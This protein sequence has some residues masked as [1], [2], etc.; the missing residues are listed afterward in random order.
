MRLITGA[1]H[2]VGPGRVDF[3]PEQ[4]RRRRQVEPNLEQDDDADRP[5]RIAEH[6]EL[7]DVDAIARRQHLPGDHGEYGTWE[8]LDEADAL[9]RGNLIEQRERE[10]EDNGRHRIPGECRQPV[11]VLEPRKPRIHELD[12]LTA[13]DMK[14]DQDDGTDAEGDE[15][16]QTD[17]AT[18]DVAPSFCLPVSEHG[19]L[20]EAGRPVRCRPDGDDGPDRD[21]TG[22]NVAADVIDNRQHV[23]HAR[24]RD[25]NLDL[26]DQ[27]GIVNPEPRHDGEQE[28]ERREDGEKPKERERRAVIVDMV[29]LEPM[30]DVDDETD[31]AVEHSGHP[32]SSYY[33]TN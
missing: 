18:D 27:Q 10:D 14:H 8:R 7:V 19:Q 33:R 9:L 32:F 29:V 26:F 2:M 3:S 30:A 13:E 23:P 25:E 12:K 24:T 31:Q 15:R 16:E 4:H 1:P 5:V 28:D 11:E 21:E 17:Q 22:V 20:D 6:R